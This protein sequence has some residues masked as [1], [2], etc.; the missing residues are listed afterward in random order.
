M[1]VTLEETQPPLPPRGSV[2]VPPASQ[3][4]AASLSNVPEPLTVLLAKPGAPGQGPEHS[5][6]RPWLMGE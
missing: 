2:M 4:T 5:H 3:T 1:T 6:R